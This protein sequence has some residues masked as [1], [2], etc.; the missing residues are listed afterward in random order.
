MKAV[1]DSVRLPV[2]VMIRP[3]PGDFFYSAEEFAI[4]REGIRCAQQTGMD[5]I[6]LGLLDGEGQ[7]DVVR[8]RQLVNLAQPLPVTFHR[9][10]D[11][12]GD[13]STALEAVI[14]AGARCILTSGGQPRAVDGLAILAQL[15]KQAGNRIVIMPGGGVDADNAMQVLQN[16]S[17][18]EIH[19]SL[20]LSSV[21]TDQHNI[22]AT[23]TEWEQDVRRLRATLR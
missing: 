3:R 10:F 2:H 16:T 8:T 17:A 9:A 22:L 15:V 13:L 21:P 20:G 12:C 18:R 6:V 7:V 14:G 11:A 4:M 5:G 19:A 23:L 1:R